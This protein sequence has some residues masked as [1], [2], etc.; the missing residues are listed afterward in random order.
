M[1]AGQWYRTVNGKPIYFGVLRDPDAALRKYLA[2]A[3]KQAARDPKLNP[4]IDPRDVTIKLGFN[5]FLTARHADVES[6][7]LS[8]GQYLRY[9]RAAQRVR[10]CFGPQRRIDDLG[11]Q[12]F[13]RLRSTLVGKPRTIGNAIRDIRVAF[14]WVADFYNVRPTFGQ[15]FK[16]P[17]AKAIRAGGKKR[18][19]FAAAEIRMILAVAEPNLR[20]MI[21]LAMN[22]GFGQRD[23]ALFSRSHFDLECH[24][25]PR[26]KTGV[27]RRCPLWP[28]TIAAIACSHRWRPDLFPEL[29]FLSKYGKILVRD[30]AIAD[31]HGNITRTRRKDAIQQML[32]RACVRAD[33]KYRPFYTLRHTFRSVVD[34]VS[35]ATAIRAIMGWSLPGMDAVYVQLMADGAARLRVVTEMAHKWL[36]D[37]IH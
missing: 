8:A 10:D 18:E 25:F 32:R 27:E 2:W 23:C 13:E 31:A 29:V 17:T 21:L 28:E 24:W 33:V 1:G 7:A 11:P 4:R 22:C 37:S 6:G 34:R 9:R 19:L 36:F 15:S 16:R 26:P 20:A 12:D 35:D 30:D 3:A 5:H 14:K